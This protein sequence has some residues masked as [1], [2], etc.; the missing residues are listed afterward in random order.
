M[1]HCYFHKFNRYVTKTLVKTV[2]FY[3]VLEEEQ[4][5]EIDSCTG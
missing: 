2:K 3:V 4:N 1:T 5:G